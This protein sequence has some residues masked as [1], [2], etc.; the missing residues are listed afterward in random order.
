MPNLALPRTSFAQRL[1]RHLREWDK[2]QLLQ[3]PG[4]GF[5]LRPAIETPPAAL[6]VSLITCISAAML[7]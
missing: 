7:R 2:A 1:L 5:T 6:T 3:R 4:E